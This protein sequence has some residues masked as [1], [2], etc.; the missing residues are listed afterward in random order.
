VENITAD[1][2]ID[3]SSQGELTLRALEA[4]GYELPEVT[5]IGVDIAYATAVFCIPDDA[6]DEWKGV[7]TFPEAPADSVGGLLMPMEGDRWILSIGGRPGQHPPGDWDG[8]MEVLAGMRTRTI[9]DAVK[10]AER[11]GDIQRYGF[12]ESRLRHYEKLSR[13]PRGVL[14]LGDAICRFNPIYGQGMS[15]AALEALALRDVLDGLDGDALPQL[16]AP[17]LQKA[18]EVIDTPWA[19]AAIPDF[20]FPSTQGERPENLPQILAFGQGLFE[21]AVSDPDLHRMYMEVSH[22]LR[23]RSA[24]QEPQLVERVLSLLAEKAAAGRGAA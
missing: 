8:Y 11:I 17:Y 19:M 18:S 22:L 9:Y 15:V 12:P 2:V 7:M 13:F 20:V 23:P 24:F 1:L 3:A 16:A 21:L 5:R 6:S 4:L 14:P 10:G